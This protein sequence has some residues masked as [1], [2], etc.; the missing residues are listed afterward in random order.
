M[1]KY[2]VSVFDEEKSAYKGARALL[3]LDYDATVT[4]YEGAI[5]AKNA[6]GTISVKDWEEEGPIGTLLGMMLGS[7]VGVI[8]GP[9]G[10]LVGAAPVQ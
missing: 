7:L 6:D 1:S 9:A 8:A 10:V 5:I 2:I 4:T 3:D